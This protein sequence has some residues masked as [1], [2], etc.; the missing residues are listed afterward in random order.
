MYLT[1]VKIENIRIISNFDL[2]LAIDD[3][4]GWH[5][6][7]GDNGSGKSTVIRAIAIGLVGKDNAAALRENWSTWLGKNDSPGSIA[8][9]VRADPNLDRWVGQGNITRDPI[10]P[11]VSLPHSDTQQG[12]Y[13]NFSG[14]FTNRTVW[15]GGQ[16]WFSAAF[17]PFRRFRG[18]D[19]EYDKLY[20]SHARLAAHLSAFGEDVALSE[21]LEW[22]KNIQFRALEKDNTATKLK[23]GLLAFINSSEL[24]PH[25]AK[26][27]E[28]T[29]SGVMLDNGAGANIPV[30]E[31]SDGYR[32]VLAMTFELLRAM[33]STFGS[34]MFLNLLD[35]EAGTVNL[36]GVILID[37]IDAHLH[38]SW[39]QRIGTWFVK[40]FPKSQFLVTTHSPIICQ[41]AEHGSI[42]RLASP[43]SEE[44][45]GRVS[46]QDLDRLRY[47]NILEA[48]STEH[49]GVDVTRSSTSKDMMRELAALNIRSMTCKLTANEEK[50]RLRLQRCLP[51]SASTIK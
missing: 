41:A 49:F 3:A 1:R 7:L 9:T 12:I 8:L 48:F 26:I 10:R 27:S 50:E 45:S 28:I 33:E 30:E 21:A 20:F 11:N 25:G 46:G 4:P 36:P 40:R 35:T 29:S 47:G 24:L 32:S 34:D 15:G 38:P 37:E 2:E 43:G 31:M 39:Q 22:I 17:G 42:W 14:R 19:R 23:N 13:P 6:I 5:V 44:R 18:G 16:G 51:T